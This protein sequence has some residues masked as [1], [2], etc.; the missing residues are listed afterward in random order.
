MIK[1]RCSCG[2]KISADE[3]RA[4]KFGRCPKCGSKIR[5]PLSETM[6]SQEA[7]SKPEPEIYSL[8]EEGPQP[9]E[10]AAFEFVSEK[11]ERAEEEELPEAVELPQEETA[12][13]YELAEEETGKPPGPSAEPGGGKEDLAPRR[14]S[15]PR[16]KPEAEGTGLRR[17]SDKAGKRPAIAG[18]CLNCGKAVSFAVREELGYYCSPECRKAGKSRIPRPEEISE[19]VA[20]FNKAVKYVGLGLGGLVF[21][22]LIFVGVKLAA[23]MARP[24]PKWGWQ[25]DTWSEQ[26]ADPVV[27]SRE[28][29]VGRAEGT[30]GCYDSVGAERWAVPLSGGLRADVA[31]VISGDRIYVA[32]KLSIFSLNRS[33]GGLLWRATLPGP[34]TCGPVVD[35]GGG[36][37]VG[38][39]TGDMIPRIGDYTYV[40]LQREGDY[41]GG[42]HFRPTGVPRRAPQPGAC[43]I[44]ALDAGTGGKKWSVDT[45]NARPLDILV[46]AGK[47]FAAVS[48]VGTAP[49][50]V[51]AIDA[52]SGAVAWER[53]LEP[54]QAWCIS[55]SGDGVVCGGGQLI[56]LGMD[57]SERWKISPPGGQLGAQMVFDGGRIY[58]QSEGGTLFCVNAGDGSIIWQQPV[59]R[60]Y[61]PPV[62]AGGRLYALGIDAARPLPQPKEATRLI[63][64]YRQT[65]DRMRRGEEIIRHV[66]DLHCFDA[67]TGEEFW[68]KQRAGDR[69]AVANGRV[70]T[71]RTAESRSDMVRELWYRTWIYAWNSKTGKNLWVMDDN[72]IQRGVPPISGNVMFLNLYDLSRDQ[73]SK[74]ITSNSR[75]R[76]IAW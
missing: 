31:P 57:G 65:A 73:D 38:T 44:L 18:V 11:G 30:F 23:R 26:V 75:L 5:V 68:I 59:G 34:L 43:F 17:P 29:Y 72:G 2:Q 49:C 13:A 28:V 37:Y 69:V 21:I 25:L 7:P 22:G 39:G 20:G 41:P 53:P 4:G 10:E 60:G 16:R 27:V 15:P 32:G 74:L 42:E 70:Y 54:G 50:A 45:N 24:V 61:F 8:R 71:L 40:P 14:P 55:D 56:S 48:S 1:F 9:P 3:S 47:V 33:D 35:E 12:E 66:P 76:T 19:K 67:Q 6:P 62:V 46:T 64:A 52:A 51:Q 36:V 63:T 58:G